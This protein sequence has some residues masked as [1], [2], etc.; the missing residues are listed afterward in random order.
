MAGCAFYLPLGSL[1]PRGV[2]SR[3][4]PLPSYCITKHPAPPN[5][6]AFRLSPQSLL[7]AVF[8]L[9]FSKSSPFHSFCHFQPRFE[10]C[11]ELRSFGCPSYF[12]D[13]TLTFDL[14]TVAKGLAGVET[15]RTTLPRAPYKLKLPPCRIRIRFPIASRSITSPLTTRTPLSTS[16]RRN[17][18][19]L[20]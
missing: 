15:T 12:F 3:Y 20:M 1:F 16:S 11:P 10:L 4:S 19:L 7:A 18:P 14:L 13:R 17:M 9:I 2:A 5:S 6:A 8:A